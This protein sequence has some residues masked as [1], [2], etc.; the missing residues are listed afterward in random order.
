MLIPQRLDQM[1]DL[2][3]HRVGLRDHFRMPKFITF[4]HE[5]QIVLDPVVQFG[6]F[7]ELFFVEAMSLIAQLEMG[8]QNA[9]DIV[10]DRFVLVRHP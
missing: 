10:A 1:G 4:I 8:L 5:L 9:G 7:F 3:T 6:N 2:R